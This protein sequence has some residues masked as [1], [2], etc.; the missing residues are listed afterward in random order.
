[1]ITQYEVSLGPGIKVH[2]VVSLADDLAIDAAQA[3]AE[4]LKQ[5]MTGVRGY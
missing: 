5:H 1:M 2:K 3:D 4:Y